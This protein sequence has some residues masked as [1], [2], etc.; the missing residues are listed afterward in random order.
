[1]FLGLVLVTVLGVGAYAYTIYQQ[2][3][4]TL[5]QK[6][7]KKIG[8]ETKVIEATEPLTILLMGVDTGNVERTDPWAG[9]S[10]SMILVTVNPKTK[11]IVHC[12]T[13]YGINHSLKTMHIDHH[14]TVDVDI[15][16][17]FNS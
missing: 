2:G 5:S 9:N 16:H 11:S 15:H 1:M 7:Y 14:I 6:T 13:T 17:L 8:E 3:T 4:A 12:N 10:D